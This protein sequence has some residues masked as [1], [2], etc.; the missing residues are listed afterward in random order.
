M[1]CVALLAACGGEDG[2]PSSEQPA[3]RP[4]Q[5]PAGWRTVTNPKAAF[6][7]A[8]P[9]SWRVSQRPRATLVSSPD[10]TTAVTLVADR[11]PS[12]RE[13]DSESYAR[14]TLTELPGF[15]GSVDAE[16]KPVEGSPYSSALVQG[17]GKLPRSRAQQRITVAALHRPKRVT[18]AL[19]AFRQREVPLGTVERMLPT[20]RGG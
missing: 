9:R 17:R 18:Y 11:T 3:D 15:E 1:G 4:A 2:S 12:G 10:R 7:V 8:V 5:P 16:A 6:S 19:V 14:Q 20:V 13:T